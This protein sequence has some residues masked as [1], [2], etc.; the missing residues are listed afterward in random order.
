MFCAVISKP[1]F[2][3]PLHVMGEPVF[4]YNRVDGKRVALFR[5][6]AH[7]PIDDSFCK[8]TAQGYSILEGILL[9]HSTSQVSEMIERDDHSQLS[10]IHGQFACLHYNSA[11]E[12]LRVYTNLSNN[13]RVYYYYLND[14]FVAATSIKMIISTLKANGITCSP[15]ELG[16]RMMLT[17]GYMLRNYTTIAEIRQLG[18]A[19]I[20]RVGITGLSQKPYFRYDTKIKHSSYRS[21]ATD[22]KE[23]FTNAVNQGLKRDGDSRHFAF[24]SGGLDSRLVVWTAHE[25]GVRDLDCLTFSQPDYLDETIARQICQ[26]LGYKHHFYSLEGGEYLKDLDANLAYHEGQIVL[27]GAAHLYAAIQTM[28]LQEY[29]I[30]HSGQIGDVIKGSYLQARGHTPVNFAAGAYS[31]RLIHTLLQEV[32]KYRS[33]YTNHEQFILENRGFNCITN[34]DLACLDFGYSVSPFVEPAFMQYSISVDPALRA[35]ARMY[36]AWMQRSYPKASKFKWEKF[37]CPVSTPYYLAR[38]KYNF[39][40]G[41]DKIKRKITKQPNTLNMNPFDYWWSSN[42]SL[43]QHF[44]PLFTIPEPVS[45]IISKELEQDIAKMLAV[46]NLSEKLQAYTVIASLKYLLL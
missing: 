22:L 23:L 20:L 35:G 1:D 33:D 40:R 15:D 38:L 11:T 24:I 10:T 46:G 26:T 30:M 18:V 27:H 21:C 14:L 31:T 12:E 7:K 29:G 42:P 34:G 13:L 25:Q 39:W 19:N 43:K 36:I 2:T 6:L 41:T 45:D 37:N 9:S 32:S 17:Y 4:Q 28:P 16:L 5:S 8:S 3:L 44:N